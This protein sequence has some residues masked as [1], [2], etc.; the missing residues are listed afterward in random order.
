MSLLVKANQPRS[1]RRCSALSGRGDHRTAS[2][3]D[4][5][6]DDPLM[7]LRLIT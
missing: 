2:S 6:S 5:V 1:P 7:I 4:L 3:L